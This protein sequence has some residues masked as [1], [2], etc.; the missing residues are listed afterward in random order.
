[1]A[2]TL[3]EARARIDETLATYQ[4]ASLAAG[5]SLLPATLTAG[6]VYEAWVLCSVLDRLRNSEGYAVFLRRSTKVTLKSAPGPINRAFPCFELSHPGR[7]PI[8]VWT[9]V[10]F[11]ALSCSQR[12]H[13]AGSKAGDY[14]ELDIVAVDSG[15]TG[16]PRHDE[17][18]D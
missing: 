9:D 2:L 7:R 6:K 8:E 12:G 10:E 16:R 17:R 5:T 14:H 11:L 4:T 15:T 1:M 3:E 13:G 18:G